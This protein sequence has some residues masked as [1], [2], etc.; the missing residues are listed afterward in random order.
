[1]LPLVPLTLGQCLPLCGPRS[2]HLQPQTLRLVKAGAPWVLFFSDRR[3][4]IRLWDP[5][6][7]APVL[8]GAQV[9]RA[10][11]QVLGS[12]AWPG[13]GVPA[14]IAFRAHVYLLELRGLSLSISLTSPG[15]N[16]IAL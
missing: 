8:L 5:E 1:M 14:L 4:F 2:P 12:Q 9:W 15:I 7:G 16:E 13:A 11:G 6:V 10:L 3:L